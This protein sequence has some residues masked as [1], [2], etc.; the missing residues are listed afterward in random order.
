MTSP[1][2]RI[3]EYSDEWPGLFEEERVRIIDAL[4]IEARFVEHIGSTSVP[5]L[6]AKPI[7]DMMVGI[8]SMN[9]A[10]EFMPPEVAEEVLPVR[11]ISI[12]D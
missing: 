11:G 6:G 7:V 1:S 9:Q 10:D 4:G 8:P 2:Y 12:G 5:G 3:V